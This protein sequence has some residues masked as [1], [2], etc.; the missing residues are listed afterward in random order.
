MI[1]RI[2]LAWSLA[3]A[4]LSF[5]AAAPRPNILFIVSEDNGPELGCYGNPHVRTPNL[6]GL[7][8]EGVRFDRAYVTQAGCSQS[9]SSIMTGLYPHQNGQI[10]LATWGFR[11]YRP[12][13]PNLPRS[14][15]SAGYR[16]GII[17]KLHI[18]PEEAFPF[19][20]SAIPSGNFA[21]KGLRDYARH[22]ETFFRASD[23]PF[24]LSVNFPD[25]HQPW[26][27]Q[28]DG[29]PAN[30]LTGK[31]VTPMA[32]MGVDR[33]DLRELVADYYNSMSRLDTLVGD[34]L[35]ALARAGKAENTLVLYIGDHG[36]DMLR[37][38][39]TCYEGGVRIPLLVRWPAGVRPGQVRRELV[40]T[41]DFMPTVLELAGAA[42]PPGL[43]GRSL[44]P[45]LK[46]EGAGW[47]THLFT[48]F[49][50]HAAKANF[51]P[52]RAVRDDRFKL[53]ENLLPGEVN[54]GYE[55]TLHHL[56]A[57]LGA[58]IAAAPA[59]VRAAYARME[60]PP[61]WELYDLRSDPYEFRDLATDPAHAVTLKRLQAELGRWRSE[62]SDPLLN[63]ANLAR[64]KAEIGGATKQDAR[65][66]SW[67][68]PYYFNGQEPPAR[69]A[70][71]EPST[72]RK[73]RKE[74]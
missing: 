12:D 74:K 17:G 71:S 32:Y 73:K 40:S 4:A 13:I 7:A 67:D 14:L 8:S 55:F 63:P 64:L 27:R 66:Q 48:E 69:S 38:K 65:A 70:A 49:H 31:D 22:A 43:A 9:R 21:R 52:Q 35:A 59:E 57:D 50:T 44:L 62:T 36:A 58:A 11:L 6:D 18:N 16:T 15:K 24:F 41:V 2:L 28:V 53:I 47:R 5:A 3:G 60:K 51:W 37:G 1:P 46:G 30:P 33:P 42:L 26:T 34:V 23:E 61:R 20:F 10:G 72:S 68:Y 29:L 19:D 54:P 45:L 25:A 39:R 56:D